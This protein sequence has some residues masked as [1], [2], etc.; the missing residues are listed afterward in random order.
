M[1]STVNLDYKLEQAVINWLGAAAT[2]GNTLTMTRYHV[3]ATDAY[4]LP[5]II[6]R[7]TVQEE[8]LKDSGHFRCGVEVTLRTQADDTTATAAETEWQMIRAILCWDELAARL[9][10]LADFHSWIV[11]RDQGERLDIDERHQDRVY[12]FTV[13]CM[14]NDNS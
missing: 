7:G 12:G 14:A 6:V 11:I 8:H 4:A 10:D 2:H 3:D 9:S 13:I 5:A 1:P